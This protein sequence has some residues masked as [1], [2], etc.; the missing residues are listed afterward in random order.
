MRTDIDSKDRGSN[1]AVEEGHTELPKEDSAHARWPLVER[2][3]RTTDRRQ[4][5]TGSVL[6]HYDPATTVAYE[7]R[8]PAG[9]PAPNVSHQCTVRERQIIQ[10]LLQGM[11]NKRIAQQLGI[12]EDTVKKHLQHIYDKLGVR[13]RTLVMLGRVTVKPT[14]GDSPAAHRRLTG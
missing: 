8:E 3:R 10:L 9:L 12:M 2:R 13:R 1:R 7:R 6:L 4:H 14:E 5:S 11:T